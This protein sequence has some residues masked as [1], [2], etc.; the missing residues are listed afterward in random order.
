MRV[1]REVLR[2]PRLFDAYV[3][4]YTPA[5]L[6]C[7]DPAAL[8]SYESAKLV[9]NDAP[10]SSKPIR[11]QLECEIVRVQPAGV[12]ISGLGNLAEADQMASQA[13]PLQ[14]VALPNG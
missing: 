5:A 12:H 9:S 11:C 8:S 1:P 6:L 13:P 4:L 14:N 3:K 2:R 7:A 10:H